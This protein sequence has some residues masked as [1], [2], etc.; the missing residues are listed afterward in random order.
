MIGFWFTAMIACLVLAGV[1]AQ[2]GWQLPTN[3]EL[4]RVLLRVRPGT[5]RVDSRTR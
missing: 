2:L 3:D 5:R 1:V 4:R